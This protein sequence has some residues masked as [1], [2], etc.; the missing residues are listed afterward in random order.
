[1]ESPNHVSA[2]SQKPPW[3]K[4]LYEWQ[5]YPDNYTDKTYLASVL[6]NVNQVKIPF[7]RLV[8]DSAVIT[9]QVSAVAIFCVLFLHTYYSRVSARALMAIEMLLLLAGWRGQRW[10]LRRDTWSEVPTSPT[11]AA[12]FILSAA[13]C[14]LPFLP[15]A[16]SIGSL[17][18]APVPVAHY[19]SALCLVALSLPVTCCLSLCP[20]PSGRYTTLPSALCSPPVAFYRYPLL[21]AVCPLPS[22]LISLT[23]HP[24]PLT[25]HHS[26]LLVASDRC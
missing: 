3:R 8:A 25:T 6:T 26:P 24:S 5:P 19:C 11:L 17:P 7:K 16:A 9:R 13:R 1:M 2:S 20:L 10:V 12:R 21:L 18:A 4:I 22:A 14:P 15:M 23:T